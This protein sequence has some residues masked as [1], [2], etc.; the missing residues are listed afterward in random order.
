MSKNHTPTQS[1]PKPS[2]FLLLKQ[3]RFVPFF[4]TQFMGAF[5]DN[6]YKNVLIILIAFSGV[7][8]S[9]TLINLCA[10]LFTLPFFLFSGFVGQLAERTEKAKLI[11]Y[12]KS[13]EVVIMCCA[14]VAFYLQ[15]ITFLIILLFLMGTQSAFFGPVKYAYIPQHLH[16]KELMGGNALV[17]TGT[18]VAILLGTLLAGLIM[19]A[20]EYSIAMAAVAVIVF[21][22]LG[23]FFSLFIPHSAA[24]NPQLRWAWNPIKETF[25]ILKITAQNRTVF[26]AVLALS[27]FWMLGAVYLTQIA[28]FSKL[29]LGGDETV[30]TLLLTLFSVGIGSGALLCDKLSK[31]DIE[32][33]LVP[34]GAIGLSIFGIDLYFASYQPWEGALRSALPFMSDWHNWR[35]I[36]DLLLIGVFGGIYTVPLYATIQSHADLQKISRIIAGNNV[37]NA[38]F[39]TMAFVIAILLLSNGF[40][41]PELL[42]FMSLMNIVVAIV[43][44]KADPQ[45]FAHFKQWLLSRSK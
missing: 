15:S 40:S 39:I 28:N 32:K 44:C 17:E 29:S 13:L 24:S 35:V 45:L 9:N 38:L 12:L 22:F 14:A 41:I 4:A 19:S 27:W 33:G 7:S 25:N 37:I 16:P 18:F 26:T 8:N 42:L 6:V 21:A 3:K 34:L 1:T 30:I 10:A 23:L 36:I 2:Q 11:R 43:L 5:N 20:N 31:R